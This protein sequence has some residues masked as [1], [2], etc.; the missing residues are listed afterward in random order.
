MVFES[1]TTYVS[2]ALGGPETILASVLLFAM[3]SLFRLMRPSSDIAP[4]EKRVVFLQTHPPHAATCRTLSHACTHKWLHMH[5]RTTQM[6]RLQV[7]KQMPGSPLACLWTHDD[8]GESRHACVWLWF[9]YL[10]LPEGLALID[11][12]ADACLDSGSPHC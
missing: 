6:S 10:A 9:S 8:I 1:L 4:S 7:G 12:A 2:R 5:R 11:A 3:R